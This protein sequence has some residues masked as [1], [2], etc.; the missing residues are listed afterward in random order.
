[1]TALANRLGYTEGQAYSMLIGLLLLW[2]VSANGLPDVV[3]E[4]GVG[5]AAP[6]GPVSTPGTPGEQRSA[7]PLSN[8]SPEPQLAASP[9]LPAGA[10]SAAPASETYAGD[11]MAT[12]GDSPAFDPSGDVPLTVSAAGFASAGA[13]TPLATTGIPEDGVPVTRRAGQPYNV[14]YL[15][16]AGRG[17]QLVLNVHADSLSTP[18]ALVG[19]QLCVVTESNWK[20][21]RGDTSLTDAPDYDCADAVTGVAAADGSTWSFDVSALDLREPAGVA[22]IPLGEG[23]SPEFQIIFDV[24]S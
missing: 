15:A 11:P 20:V 23:T 19:I 21:G 17:P 13:G 22:L 1:M 12:A 16:L 9:V 8:L 10:T 4:R 2:V 6:V 3:W 7:G 24:V 5:F 18:A 14:A